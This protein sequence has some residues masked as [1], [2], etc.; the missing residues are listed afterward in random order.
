MIRAPRRLV[1]HVLVNGIVEVPLLLTFSDVGEQVAWNGFLSLRDVEQIFD[2]S[3]EAWS[4]LLRLGRLGTPDA[5]FNRATNAGKLAAI[6]SVQRLRT[7]WT[8]SSLAFADLPKLVAAWGAID[9]AVARNLLAHAGRVAEK[10]GGALPAS[11]PVFPG[12]A[13]HPADAGVRMHAGGAYLE[14]LYGHLHHQGDLDWLADQAPSIRLCAD[15]LVRLRWEA[16]EL[17]ANPGIQ[18]EVMAGLAHAAVLAEALGDAVNAERWMSE[19]R[20]A[21]AGAAVWLEATNSWSDWRRRFGWSPQ[22]G[23]VHGAGTEFHG[24]EL[25]ASAVWGGCGLSVRAGEVWIEP[26]WPAQWSWWALFSLPLVGGRHISILWDG[27]TLHATF[28]VRSSLPVEVQ[29]RIQIHHT[30]EFDFD[31][32]IELTSDSDSVDTSTKRR[33]RPAFPATV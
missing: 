22:A 33:F 11:F 29:K 12:Q 16:P 13:P 15:A 18:Q 8:P 4:R 30:D 31:P 14:A 6:R 32:L 25:A 24:A 28:P 9:L 10:T 19:V 5:A 21:G 1:Y 20:A 26:T 3:S 23:T 7:G 2:A 17:L 27:N